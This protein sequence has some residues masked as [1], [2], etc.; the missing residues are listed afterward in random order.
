MYLDERFRRRNASVHDESDEKMVVRELAAEVS[1]WSRSPEMQRI[2]KRWIDSTEKR[3][4][5]RPPVWCNPVGCWKELLPDDLLV[6]RVPELREMEVYFKRLL[7]KREIGDDTLA[8]AVYDVG[9]VIDVSPANE[10]GLDIRFEKLDANGSAWRYLPSLND[11]A[12]FDKLTVPRY[13]WNAEATR[14]RR[15]RAEECLGDVMPVR[16]NVLGSY[17]SAANL[18]VKAAMLRGLEPMMMDMICE[19]DLVHRLM[20]V[21][22]QGVMNQLDELEACGHLFPNI[23]TAMLSSELL[24][25]NKTGKTTLADCWIHGNSQE[26]DQVSPEMFE[27]FL[28]NYQKPIFAR[29]GAVC[30]GCCENLTHKLDAV[31]SIPNLKL[32]TC[33]A[34]TDMRTLVEKNNRR[35]CIM[36]RHKASDVVCPDTLGDFGKKLKE[37]TAILGDSHYQVILRELQTLMGHENRLSEWTKLCIGA[38]S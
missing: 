18:S 10:W 12:D 17:F 33:S 28:L 1:E 5:D 14:I 36:W 22:R 6:C 19:P 11:E 2:R 23:D 25:E 29:F 34:W 3:R 15:D 30:Y 7:I 37:Q 20:T 31:L 9:P 4:Y 27:G 38:V 8:A 32:L 24:R 26:F 16:I 21:M 35:C 13:H